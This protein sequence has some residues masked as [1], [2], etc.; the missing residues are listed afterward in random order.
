MDSSNLSLIGL[1]QDDIGVYI[2]FIA[3]VG[4][5][6]MVWKAFNG[7]ELPERRLQSVIQRREDLRAALKAEASGKTLLSKDMLQRLGQHFKSLPWLY[8]S[9]LRKN[10]LRAGIRNKEAM[11]IFLLCK[12]VLPLALFLW[13]LLL[14]AGMGVGEHKPLIKILLLL[15]L[16]LVAFALPGIWLKN[17]IQKREE[18]LRKGLPD[19]FD[20]LVIC[21][22]SGLGLDA[23]MDRV[24]REIVLSQPVL[25]EEIGITAVE[26]GFLPD[27]RVALQGFADRVQLPSIRALVNTLVQSEKYGTP[28]AQALRVLS[29]EMRDE[30]MMKAEEKAAKLPATLTVPM[31]LFILPTLFIVLLGPAIIQVMDLNK[32]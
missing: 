15:G 11:V 24:A 3:L 21:A 6:F 32:H 22:E 27:R 10:L 18:A 1:L 7:E 26:L 16:P 28:L 9:D 17:S 12:L 23:A 5:V 20:L 30:R 2:A 8:S 19:G 25:A 4:A 13:A 29:A 31:I 14:T